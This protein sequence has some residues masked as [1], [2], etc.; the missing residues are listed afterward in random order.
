VTQNSKNVLLYLAIPP[1]GNPIVY[2]VYESEYRQFLSADE[3]VFIQ[4][5]E[6]SILNHFESEKVITGHSR[7]LYNLLY[8]HI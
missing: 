4:C 8:K 5:Y 2:P 3:K 1:M 6:K 7:A